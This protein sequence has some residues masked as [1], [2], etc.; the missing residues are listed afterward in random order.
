MEIKDK[1]FKAYDIR[2][3]YPE[4]I[5]EVVA[6]ELGK[7]FCDIY[8]KE[9][10]VVGYD[11]RLSSANLS[12]EIMRSAE[13]SGLNP[14]NIGLV[15]SDHFYVH[16]VSNKVPG[17]MITASHN[18]AEYNGF[19]MLS[20]GG[21]S[22]RKGG[23]MEELKEKINKKEKVP[24]KNKKGERTRKDTGDDFIKKLTDNVPPLSVGPLS[25]VIDAGNGALGP[26]LE[27][28]TPLYKDL[29]VKKLFWEPD[30]KFPN[31]DPDPL[32]EKAQDSLREEVM[33]NKGSFGI[34]FDGDGDRVFVI[35]EEGE[36][37]PSD[38]LG[39]ILACYFLDLN[40]EEKIIKDVTVS[41]V[42][43]D[44]TAE[45]NKAEVIT[46]RVGH[47]FIKNTMKESGSV[48]GVEKS[49]H[50]YFRNLY[51][52]DSGVMAMLYL[53]R[54]LSEKGKNL[55]EAVDPL[56]NSYFLTGQI[57]L[58]VERDPSEILKTIIFKYKNEDI[59]EI[60]GVSVTS[61]N[62]DWRV[63]I[64]PSNT[65]PVVRLVAEASSSKLLDEKVK[66]FVREIEPTNIKGYSI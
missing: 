45:Y 20:G 37:V 5:N 49:G 52:A 2:G 46:E 9:K 38:L 34:S 17:I 6:Y 66:E 40:P 44:I 30:G 36:F 41:K 12:E 35:D 53:L 1:I 64:R 48:L 14:V 39:G 43:D 62:K 16:C 29:K 28:L 33:K 59:G 31:R 55:K 65:E 23:G 19:K 4:E 26:C 60:D 24:I 47:S 8:G 25:V 58:V 42:I 63:V 51:R 21:H 22:I 18:P 50:F 7:A 15:S 56:R 32:K 54:Y 27:K 10:I 13:E 3:I 11:A 61:K 57:N